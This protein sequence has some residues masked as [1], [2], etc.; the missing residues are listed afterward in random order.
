MRSDGVSEDNAHEFLYAASRRVLPA[1]HVYTLRA[2]REGVELLPLME[3]CHSSEGVHVI[4][5]PVD[6]AENMK[7]TERLGKLVCPI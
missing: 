7:L 2:E 6:Y 5:C 1:G 4:D 3:R